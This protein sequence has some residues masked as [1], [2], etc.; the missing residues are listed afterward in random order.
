MKGLRTLIKLSRQELDAKR[1]ALADLL[2][3][4]QQCLDKLIHLKQEMTREKEAARMSSPIEFRFD[5][6]LKRVNV[7]QAQIVASLQ[8]LEGKIERQ[9]EEIADAYA[10]LKKFEVLLQQRLK[11]QADEEKRRETVLLNEVAIAGHRRKEGE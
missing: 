3:Q 8:T 7:E 1:K 6:Y 2:A 4:K 9:T 10:E 5:M 11:A